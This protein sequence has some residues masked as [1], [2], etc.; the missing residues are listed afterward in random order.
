M[1]NSADAVEGVTVA[2]DHY[3]RVSVAEDITGFD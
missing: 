3:P 2:L 1:I